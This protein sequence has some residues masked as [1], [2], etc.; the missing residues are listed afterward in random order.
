MTCTESDMNCLN[1]ARERR[2]LLGNRQAN[3]HCALFRNDQ[4][5]SALGISSSTADNDWAYA[6]SWLRVEMQRTMES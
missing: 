4:A 3:G 6:K 2:H 5:A 1:R